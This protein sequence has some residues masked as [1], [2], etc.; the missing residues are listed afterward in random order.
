MGN[1]K[2]NQTFEKN[3]GYH[4]E[5]GKVGSRSRFGTHTLFNTSMEKS[6]KEWINIEFKEARVKNLYSI[7]NLPRQISLNINVFV[8]HGHTTNECIPLKDVIEWMIKK[9]KLIEYTRDNKRGRGS[10]D[11]S[12][13]KK[14]SPEGINPPR[15]SLKFSRTKGKD[16]TR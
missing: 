10:Q 1:L 11:D 5:E 6:W 12:H 7:R 15:K 4:K 13:K 9:G 3:N 16:T 2:L 8:S 14:H